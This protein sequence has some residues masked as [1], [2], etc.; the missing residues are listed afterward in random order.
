MDR[1]TESMHQHR[2]GGG[3]WRW[4]VDAGKNVVSS[5]CGVCHLQ[6]PPGLL[7]PLTSA[8]GQA[9]RQSQS[10]TWALSTESFC[11]GLLTLCSPVA[12]PASG[13]PRCLSQELHQGTWAHLYGCPGHLQVGEPQVKGDLLLSLQIVL[14]HHKVPLGRKMLGERESQREMCAEVAVR[15]GL[16][17]SS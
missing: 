15:S 12:S 9:Q 13:K 1:D 14:D 8:N 11:F 2:T 10:P 3:P 16:V 7:C 17:S 5:Y 4:P 6:P